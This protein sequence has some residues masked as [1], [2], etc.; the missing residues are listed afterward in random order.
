MKVILQENVEN[1]GYVGDVLDVADG[2]ARNFLLPRKKAIEANLRN[3][4]ALEHAKRVTA[5]KAKRI[6]RDLRKWADQLSAV[7]LTFPVQT[8]RDDKLFGSITA[9]DLEAGLLTE[10][11]A[12][13]RR[14]IQLAHPLKEL[15]TFPIGI[16]VHRDVDATISV[17]LVKAGERARA[18]EA[19]DGTEETKAAPETVDATVETGETPVEVERPQE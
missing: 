1:V 13:N 4:K 3:V 9:K 17:S 14:N 8:G 10:G 18:Q 11:F 15:G 2:Y 19:E 12:V 7:S 5:H 16:K 6:E